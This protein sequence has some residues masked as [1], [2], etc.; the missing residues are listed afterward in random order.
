MYIYLYSSAL[1]V[2]MVKPYVPK[3][4]W[5]NYDLSEIRHYPNT[6]K[7]KKHAK[8]FGCIVGDFLFYNSD[9]LR[10]YLDTICGLQA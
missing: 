3:F 10:W 6:T 9:K 8:F 1:Q 4:H 7:C 5:S 2:A